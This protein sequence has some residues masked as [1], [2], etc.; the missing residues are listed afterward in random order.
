MIGSERERKMQVT[1]EM[2]LWAS[3]VLANRA[4]EQGDA[5]MAAQALAFLD[6]MRVAG[7]NGS[8]FLVMDELMAIAEGN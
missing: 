6:V 1:K 4:I 7:V 2:A 5:D 8:A 3:E